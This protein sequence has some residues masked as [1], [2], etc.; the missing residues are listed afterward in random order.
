MLKSRPIE[1]NEIGGLDKSTRCY[2]RRTNNGMVFLDEKIGYVSRI[3]GEICF[4]SSKPIPIN[5]VQEI[6]QD[7]KKFFIDC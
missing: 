3:K 1:P 4:F 7:S 2:F 5:L 6:I